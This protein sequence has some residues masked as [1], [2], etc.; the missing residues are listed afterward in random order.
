MCS[1]VQANFSKRDFF[2]LVVAAEAAGITCR[3]SK[4]LSTAPTASRFFPA[5]MHAIMKQWF[6][7][8]LLCLCLPPPFVSWAIYA[9]VGKSAHGL[10]D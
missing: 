2:L 5:C 1:A 9:F 10:Q 4:R 3:I 8:L 6:L 7:F